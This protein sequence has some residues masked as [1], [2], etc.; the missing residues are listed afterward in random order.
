MTGQAGESYNALYTANNE[1][2]IGGRFSIPAQNIY[3]LCSFNGT[4]LNGYS[5][6]QQSVVYGIFSFGTGV[7]CV[8][9]LNNQNGTCHTGLIHS[10][11]GIESDFSGVLNISVYPNPCSDVLYITTDETSTVNIINYSGALV[12][13]QTVNPG[14]GIQVSDLSSG[15]YIVDVISG[16]QTFRTRFFKK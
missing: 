8:G 11:T 6:Q 10:I 3:S 12:I 13:S 5:L 1:L 14:N 15:L 7:Y 4:Q 2:F 16:D 9:L